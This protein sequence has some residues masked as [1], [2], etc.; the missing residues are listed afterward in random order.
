[1]PP[2]LLVFASD[3]N[4]DCPCD[5][6]TLIFLLYVIALYF[7]CKLE[8]TPLAKEAQKVLYK[9]LRAERAAKLRILTVFLVLKLMFLYWFEYFLFIYW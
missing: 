1:M 7:F 9:T 8:Q 4:S 2:P 3:D 5:V 6:L